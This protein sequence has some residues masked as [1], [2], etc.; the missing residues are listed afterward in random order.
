MSVSE[1]SHSSTLPARV[2][3]A[4]NL[5]FIFTSTIFLSAF[6]LFGVQPMFTKMVLPWLGGSPGVWSIAMVFF[7]GLLLLGYLYAHLSTTYLKPR[8]AV[9]VHALLALAAFSTLP[10]TVSQAFGVPPETGQGVWL[11]VVFSASVG[12]PFFVLSATAPLLQAWFARSGHERAEN[13]YFLYVASNTGSFAALIAYPLLIEP[14]ST[15]Y[16]QRIGWMWLYAIL[17][18]ALVLCGVAAIGFAAKLTPSKE[19]EAVT[20]K[21]A[22]L[23]I[24]WRQRALWTGYASVPSGLLIAVTAHLST[25][26]ASAPLLWVVPLALFMLTFIFAFRERMFVSDEA[27]TKCFVYILPFVIMSIAGFLLPLTIQFVIH[28]GVLFLAAMLCHRQLYLRRPTSAQLTEFYLWMSFGG[29]MGGLFAGLL[30]PLMFTSIIEYRLLLIAALLCIPAAKAAPAY[31]QQILFVCF[32]LLVGGLLILA[33]PSLK[34]LHASLPFI[35]GLA[36]TTGF[37]AVIIFNRN[38]PVSSAGAAMGAFLALV[39]TVGLQDREAVVR[40]FFGVNYV[41]L[42]AAGDFRVLTHGSTFHGGVRIRDLEGKP[43]KGRPSPTL[44]YHDEGA[45]NIALEAARA[46]AGGKLGN[47]A[48]LGLGS[49]ALACQ[50]AVGETWNFFEIDA[51]VVGLARNSALFPFLGACTPD[52]RIILG[53]ARLTL[54][55]ETS[56]FDVIILD[57]FS[58]DAVPAHLLTKEAFGIYAEFLNS[59]GMIIAHVSNRHMDLRSVAE[60]GGVSLGMATA[61]ARL[62]YDKGQEKAKLQFATPSTVVAISFDEAP[63]RRLLGSGEWRKPLVGNEKALWTDDYANIIGAMIRAKMATD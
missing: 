33:G 1:I 6:L 41:K 62:G 39:V 5:A 48:V 11:L 44:Y 50:S 56:K 47:V 27:M 54:K 23:P 3:D 42:N 8:T 36:A 26:V 35:L 4:H 38:G 43:M 59:G 25:D 57:A 34:M 9:I 49:G 51:E 63:L 28:L 21:A 45:I 24:T 29:M 58:S 30:A 20:T 40:S 13:P 2:R 18:S 16:T 14:L 10:L 46:N 52:A 19:V 15:L 53:D 61:S 32:S 7:Q 31:R 22:A 60:A 12:L 17:G 55:K 37:L